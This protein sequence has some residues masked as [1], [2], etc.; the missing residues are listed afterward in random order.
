MIQEENLLKLA[1]FSGQVQNKINVRQEC[2]FFP[3]NTSVDPRAPGVLGC[4]NAHVSNVWISLFPSSYN[5][6]VTLCTLNRYIEFLLGQRCPI[7]A[8]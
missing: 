1:W 2:F 8:H 5:T 6:S 4:V 7:G 3:T